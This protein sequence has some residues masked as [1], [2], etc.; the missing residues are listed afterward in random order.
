ME[1]VKAVRVLGLEQTEKSIAVLPLVGESTKRLSAILKRPEFDGKT[2]HE[3]FMALATFYESHGQSEPI[4]AGNFTEAGRTGIRKCEPHRGNN[5]FRRS[6]ERYRPYQRTLSSRAKRRRKFSWL[7]LRA[8]K[9][10]TEKAN[11]KKEKGCFQERDISICTVVGHRDPH[12]L[13]EGLVA[14]VYLNQQLVHPHLPSLVRVRS[15]SAGVFR[16]VTMCFCGKR[17]R[18]PVLYL[19]P[20]GDLDYL[21]RYALSVLDVPA[22]QLYSGYRH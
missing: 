20:L 16:T 3:I 8:M 19:N 4:T 10:I 14:S 7:L 22:Y 21:V 18:A 1:V 15:V 9:K 13:P 2:K 12:D 17:N 5:S 6:S 11:K